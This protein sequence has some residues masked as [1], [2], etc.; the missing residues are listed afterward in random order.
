VDWLG[1][2][3]KGAL[4]A[5]AGG[6]GGAAALALA[7]AGADEVVADIDDQR[8][9]ELAQKGLRTLRADL[10]DADGGRECVARA[11]GL[12]GRL[13][14]F[15]HAVGV[16]DRRPVLDTPDDVWRRITSVNLDSAFWTGK[17][18]GALMVAR[19]YG[20]IVYLSSVSGLLAHRTTRPTPRARA[21][22]TSCAG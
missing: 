4:V 18:A 22:S 7:E 19:G 17:A 11:D 12:L 13:D 8:L 10:T 15:V 5:G 14:V 3:G 20:R 2:R 9:D 6:I 21:P 1:L 16:N